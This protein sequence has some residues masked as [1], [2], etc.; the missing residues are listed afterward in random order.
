MLSDC[1]NGILFRLNT[2]LIQG[3]L[4]TKIRVFLTSL[5]AASRQPVNGEIDFPQKNALD[6]R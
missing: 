2:L 3:M 4:G 1:T 6:P 5:A